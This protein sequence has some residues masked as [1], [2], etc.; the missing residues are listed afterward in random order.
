[1]Q[2]K[3]YVVWQPTPT[4]KA[5]EQENQNAQVPHHMQEPPNQVHIATLQVPHFYMQVGPVI[6]AQP[7]M[8]VHRSTST[9]A[10][11][12]SLRELRKGS[13]IPFPGHLID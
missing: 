7:I 8:L 9:E 13:T 5:Q 6:P 3:Q 4:P 10:L 1:M 2:A 11:S 12:L